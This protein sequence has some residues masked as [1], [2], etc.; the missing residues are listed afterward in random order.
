VAGLLYGL[1]PLAWMLEQRMRLND[2]SISYC[3][4]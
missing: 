2:L 3:G 1:P 4:G